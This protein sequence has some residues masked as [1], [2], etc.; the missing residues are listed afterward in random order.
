MV[1]K[2]LFALLAVCIGCGGYIAYD[3]RTFLKTP[4]SK[5]PKDV[6]IDIQPGATFDRVAWDLYKAG[7]IT[8]I[9]RFRVLA[10]VKRQLGSVKS[11]EFTVNTG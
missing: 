3:A 7:A 11:G 4:A 8:D 9:F 1:K 2:I 6:V 10:K 5:T